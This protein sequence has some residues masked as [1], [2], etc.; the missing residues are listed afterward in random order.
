M[1]CTGMMS[2][3]ARRIAARYWDP[4]DRASTDKEPDEQKS[5]EELEDSGEPGL[6]ERI[7]AR[8]VFATDRTLAQSIMDSLCKMIF[9]GAG[10]LFPSNSFQIFDTEKKE[11]KGFQPGYFSVG[12]LPQ[13]WVDPPN[14]Q[15]QKVLA[16]GSTLLVWGGYDPSGVVK[17]TK[18]PPG[19]SI[20]WTGNPA[21]AAE[22]V[23]SRVFVGY[24][25]KLAGGNVQDETYI[26]QI[27][28]VF[29]DQEE[30][31]VR[32][33]KPD[34]FKTSLQKAI[35]SIQQNPNTPAAPV[36]QKPA[37]KPLPTHGAPQ[38]FE[39]YQSIENF[40]GFIEEFGAEERGDFVFGP[41]D[42]NRILYNLKKTN[43]DATRKEIVD[44]LTKDPR[45]GLRYD[46]SLRVASHEDVSEISLRVATRYL[47]RS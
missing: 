17:S 4:E 8:L 22:T 16:S 26:G 30:A 33:L 44:A 40:Y 13:Q 43:K 12:L 28:V 19:S 9:A 14:P 34:L 41:H 47:K 38:D 21:M 24:Y 6:V 42:V 36:A 2:D 37:V 25:N 15:T 5:R 45:G 1:V 35:D 23:I 18:P 3:L 29:D 31:T 7:A 32:I 27:E 10:A 20:S 39:E 46:E 11:V